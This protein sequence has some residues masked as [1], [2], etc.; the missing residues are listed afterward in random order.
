M[1]GTDELD[2][3]ITKFVSLWI[4]GCNAKQTVEAEAG[5]AFVNL[6]VGL[7]QAHLGQQHHVVYH[8]R[9]GPSRQRRKEKRAAEREA[10]EKV[11]DADASDRQPGDVA[12]EAI[13]VAENVTVDGIVRRKTG[14]GGYNFPYISDRWH[15]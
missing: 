5:N 11:A 6:R 10:A 13:E 8:R 4:S 15:C 3:F 7:G 9:G 14:Y 1:A 12:V 2:K